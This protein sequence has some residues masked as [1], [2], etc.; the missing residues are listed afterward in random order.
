MRLQFGI[1][2]ARDKMLSWAMKQLGAPKGLEDAQ[3]KESQLIFWPF[4]VVEVE[5]K[6][7]YEGEQKKPD[8]RGES[9]RSSVDW[10]KVYE[11]GT[12]DIESDIFIPANPNTPTPLRDYVIPTKRKE[13]FNQD[14]ILDVQ[15]I[16]K[17]VQ[18]TQE[19]ALEI[20]KKTMQETV[21]QEALKEVDYIKKINQKFE[22]PAVFLIH[23]PIWHIKYTYGL[24]S[25]TAL[26]DGASG[27]VVHLKFPRKVAF[28]AMT[29]LG[30]LIHLVVGGGIGLLLTYLGF[31]VFGDVFPTIFGI[32]FGLGMLAFSLLFFRTALSLK[33]GVEEAR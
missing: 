4:W 9:S 5:A 30:G 32:I 6:V 3:V 17:E 22:T 8:F 18:V 11:K 28:R 10:K 19:K 12:L 26:V 29:M 16:A 15:G 20:A 7:D 27:R 24:R 2:E 14:K 31:V 21:H 23:V 1:N 25:Y 13:Y 33:A